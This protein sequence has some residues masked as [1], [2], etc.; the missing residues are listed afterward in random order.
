MNIISIILYILYNYT[1]LCIEIGEYCYMATFADKLREESYVALQEAVAHNEKVDCAVLELIYKQCEQEVKRG[2]FDYSINTSQIKGAI[3]A[4]YYNEKFKVAELGY[5]ESFE[6]Q[7]REF[8][9]SSRIYDGRMEIPETVKETIEKEAK[10]FWSHR[11]DYNEFNVGSHLT[12]LLEAE[13][14]EVETKHVGI[15]S[16]IKVTLYW[17]NSMGGNN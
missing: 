3:K 5:I 8:E 1:V 16:D 11:V 9:K 6:E 2:K 17:S 15:S 14:F 4:D 10:D 12:N 13:G 7:K